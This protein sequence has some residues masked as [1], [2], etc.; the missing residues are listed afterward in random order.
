MN[1]SGDDVTIEEHLANLQGVASRRQIA[2]Q[3]R[4]R[5][6][7]REVE[8][9]HA[10]LLQRSSSHFAGDRKTYQSGEPPVGRRE[11]AAKTR[12]K[13]VGKGAYQTRLREEAAEYWSAVNSTSPAK[14]KNRRDQE[15]S[16]ASSPWQVPKDHL[17]SLEKIRLPDG[18]WYQ[19]RSGYFSFNDLVSYLGTTRNTLKQYSKAV[20]IPVRIRGEYLVSEWHAKLL[21]GFV[22][23]M[24]YR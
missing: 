17:G 19:C 6:D 5:P 21:I 11:G 1:P 3:L 12:R 15:P 16:C 10:S 14:S 4:C 18:T 7:S 8:L 24:S 23:S 9:A 13:H 2:V 22:R 20:G